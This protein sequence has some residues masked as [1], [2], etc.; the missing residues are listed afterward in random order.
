MI[1]ADIFSQQVKQLVRDK[2]DSLAKH[3]LVEHINRFAR[4]ISPSAIHCTSKAIFEK[5]I[6]IEF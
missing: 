4:F 5:I 6:K 3:S 1:S 2:H